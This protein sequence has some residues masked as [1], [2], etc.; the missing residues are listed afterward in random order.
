MTVRLFNRSLPLTSFATTATLLAVSA[1]MAVGQTNHVDPRG[2]VTEES[3][4][5]RF[6]SPAMDR[7]FLRSDLDGSAKTDAM[8]PPSDG[9]RSV[10]PAA[11]SFGDERSL[12]GR[13]DSTRKQEQPGGYSILDRSDDGRSG[14][15]DV[16]SGFANPDPNVAPVSGVRAFLREP[17]STSSSAA[18]ATSALPPR[19]QNT[20]NR[21]TTVVAANDVRSRP[22]EPPTPGRSSASRP[23]SNGQMS[24][25]DLRDDRGMQGHAPAKSSNGF[26]SLRNPDSDVARSGMQNER[27][28]QKDV[29]VD[30]AVQPTTYQAPAN[31]FAPNNSGAGN[32]GQNNF[33]Q[34][35]SRN[36]SSRQQD[37][38]HSMGRQPQ[39]QRR[40]LQPQ[41]PVNQRNGTPQSN[42]P[43]A[44]GASDAQAVIEPF[45]FQD[46]AGQPSTGIAL[47]DALRQSQGRIARQPLVNQYWETFYDHA[48]SV[49]SDRLHQ[50]YETIQ[51]S[52]AADA[53]SVKVAISSSQNEGDSNRIQLGKSQAKLKQMLGSTTT[54]T[55]TDVP[56]VTRVGTNYDAFKQRGLIPPRFEGIDQTLEELHAL[57]Q[58]R[59]A[60]A[61]LSRKTADEVKQFYSRSQASIEH[62]LSAGRA[63]RAAEADFIA[64]TVEYN[65]AYADYALALPYGRG[66]V[67]KVVGMLITGPSSASSS[68]SAHAASSVLSSS[69]PDLSRQPSRSNVPSPVRSAS[70]S[71]GT[72]R[73]QND[74]RRDMQQR[75]P[76]GSGQFSTSAA[77]SAAT[78][79]IAQPVR[80]SQPRQP[81]PRPTARDNDAGANS[82]FSNNEFSAGGSAS[83]GENRIKRPSQFPASGSN[84]GAAA[85]SSS[86]ASSA[87]GFDPG[88]GFNPGQP[89][90]SQPSATKPAAPGFNFGG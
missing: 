22:V 14:E 30:R 75:Q 5:E 68:S 71:N 41:Q 44:A 73:P 53:A 8:A 6:S 26:A 19:D 85:A 21:S 11:S 3:Q 15:S 35:N 90:A 45:R 28:Q 86:P 47:A 83:A 77:S 7:G 10:S 37:Q 84:G 87:S 1:S 82:G 4:F 62:L 74:G 12:D 79:S 69:R 50:W 29:R 13:R 60:T 48:Q 39:Q 23:I 49:S 59:A 66:P 54:L 78:N 2:P 34:G 72:M 64:S 38:N 58:S 36:G 52:K 65:K 20:T 9:F 42:R 46:H 76:T 63:W 61:A 24:I 43:V 16:S 70:R 27:P 32:F 31:G 89:A 40:T 88:S 18:P 80:Q 67:E 25:N 56:T 33:S 81:Q 57:V 17:T 51:A 55:P